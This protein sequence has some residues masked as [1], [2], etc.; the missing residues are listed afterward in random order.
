MWIHLI[1]LMISSI[2]V[3]EVLSIAIPKFKKRE[4]EGNAIASKSCKIFPDKRLK[5]VF[6][7]LSVF[8][9]IIGMILLF[10]PQLC[11]LMEFD[12]LIVNIIW[13]SVTLLDSIAVFYFYQTLLVEYND[14]FILITNIFRKTHKIG[15][16][17]IIKVT[18][19]IKI[20]TKEKKFFIP[21]SLFYGVS[22]LKV[23]IM[24]QKGN[25]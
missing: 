17:D 20:C 1:S 7:G 8:C 22:A 16:S 5:I 19:N 15:Y 23:K 12:W 11:E 18:T 4:D 21:C 24:T 13:W 10:V 25:Q 6:I 9:L 3:S 14:D 2:V